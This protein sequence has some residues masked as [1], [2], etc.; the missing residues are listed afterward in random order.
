MLTITLR[1]LQFRRRQ[2]GIAVVGAAVVFGLTL[3]LTGMSAGLTIAELGDKPYPAKVVRSAGAFDPITRTMVVELI[4]PNADGA[5]IPGMYGQIKFQLENPQPFLLVPV[6]AVMI[7]GEGVRVAT[8]DSKDVV[9]IK[10]VHVGIQAKGM[11][12]LFVVRPTP[13]P[14]ASPTS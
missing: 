3:L 1:D 5:L 4:V 12:K 9:H 7:G 11:S 13:A 2:F 10:K 6:T 14:T 8:I